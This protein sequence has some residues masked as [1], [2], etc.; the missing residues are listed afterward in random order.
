MRRTSTQTDKVDAWFQRFR[1]LNKLVPYLCIHGADIIDPFV[2]HQR[3]RVGQVRAFV[4]RMVEL[5]GVAR[6][7]T[8]LSFG[9]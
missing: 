4:V 1:N 2:V 5:A 6:R 8:R 3:G 7:A 9:T